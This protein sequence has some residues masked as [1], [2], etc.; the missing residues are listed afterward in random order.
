MLKTKK[1][2]LFISPAFFGY[3]NSIIA[4]ILEYGYSVDFFD[5]RTS[6]K[7]FF[8]AIF[9]IN[10]NLVSFLIDNYYKKIWKLVT[11]NQYDFLLLIKGEVIPEW[12]IL[13]FKVNNPKAILVYYTYD[14]S[15]NNNVNSSIIIK[16]FHKCF[17]FDFEDVIK[18]PIFKLKHLFFTNEFKNNS[19]LKIE[20]RKY[21]ISFVGTIHSNR[22][23]KIKL[24]FSNFENTHIFYY[25]P[26]KWLFYWYK[27][28]NKLFKDIK[29][30]EISFTKLSKLQV[31]EI[32]KSSICVL[33]IQR[34]GQTGLT[35]RTFEVLASGSFL[36]TT[37]SYIK[38]VDFYNED[39]I[40]ILDDL[41]NINCTKLINEKIS[42]RLV[43]NENFESNLNKYSINNWI[44]EFF[45]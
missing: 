16:H 3:E 39:Y 6:N 13:K 30:S 18:N 1:S 38:Y 8:K 23:N 36:I 42:S 29:L 5:E 43:K 19:D 37:N 27:I 4:A 24:L 41:S 31:A 22:Y 32:F 34:I 45:E 15:N 10:K 20:E 33:D 21:S 11:K 14:S 35:M 17:S 25:L 28:S 2:V 9:R 7:S 26:A 12:F 40:L 44:I